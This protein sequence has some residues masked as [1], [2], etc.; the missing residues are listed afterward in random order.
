MTLDRYWI[1]L[2]RYR[3][4]RFYA[5][6]ILILALVAF[7]AGVNVQSAQ[8]TMMGLEMRTATPDGAEIGG[9]AGCLNC[10][11][12]QQDCSPYCVVPIAG[13]A[14]TSCNPERVQTRQSVSFSLFS[15]LVG[16]NDPPELQPPNFLF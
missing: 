12:D 5:L 1:D 16:H 3:I 9:C 14:A 15:Y 7:P 13:I 4:M 10:D 2:V 6:I 11:D 8:A